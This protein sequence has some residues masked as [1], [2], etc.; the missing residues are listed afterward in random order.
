M[1]VEITRLDRLNLVGEMAASIGSWNQKSDDN[2]SG[3]L[4]ILQENE[5]Y[6]NEKKYFIQI[7]RRGDRANAIITHFFSLAKDKL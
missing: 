1:E 7:D 4:Q 2:R 5:D 3:F 6:Q